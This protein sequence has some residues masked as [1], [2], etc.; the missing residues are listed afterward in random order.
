[1][2][3]RKISIFV[4]CLVLCLSPFDFLIANA[5][6]SADFSI[7]AD[8]IAFI[9]AR[10][11]FHSK[12][13]KDNTQSSIGYGTKCTGSSE[14]PHA[15]GLH[16]ITKEAAMEAMRSQIDSTYAPRVKK[17][18]K[19]I[20]MNQNQFDALV[21]LCYNTGGGTT[22]ISNSPLVKYLKGLLSESEARSNYSN[23]YVKSG[24]TVLQGLINR[25]NQ[26]A[27]LFFS[28]SPSTNPDDYNEPTSNYYYTSPVMTGSEVGWIQAV[29][30]QLGYSITIDQSYGP[31]TRDVVTQFQT[32]NNLTID[33]MCG[34]QSRAKLLELWN[35]KKGIVTS[36][37]TLDINIS[38]NNEVFTGGMH[39]NTYDVYINGSIVANDVTDYC[40]TFADGT[41]YRIEDIKAGTGYLYVGNT[42]Y[43]GTI[44][45]DF[46][47]VRL[48]FFTDLTSEADYSLD[49]HI[50][51]FYSISTTWEKAKEYAE[52]MGGHL[53]AI[54]SEAEQNIILQYYNGHP[55][56]RLW[57]GATDEV[58]EETWRWVTGEQFVY[59]NWS[60]GEPNNVDNKEHYLCTTTGNYWNDDVNDSPSV[61]GFVVEYEPTYIP[62]DVNGDDSVNNKDLTRLMKYLAG[63]DV[64]VN[65]SS[66]DINGDGNVNNKDLTRLMKYLAGEDVVIN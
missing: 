57:L 1:M 63:E 35:E 34:P 9:C 43:S 20:S 26:E 41:T 59:D 44:G 4:L 49:G 11:G 21:S 48:P 19:D 64:V 60:P 33:G 54:T 36:K 29:L 42:T 46:V 8:G 10:E 5:S 14:Q 12:C 16:S 23:Y 7:S 53:A 24:G 25:R 15:S 47:E 6:T 65:D 38:I 50:Y 51:S 17:Q 22:I 45:T 13:Y 27:D 32:D 40:D 28:G 55:D 3:I 52:S 39:T 62:G 18:T 2:R 56:Q 58:T 61:T 37:Y 31:K 66:L 30:Y